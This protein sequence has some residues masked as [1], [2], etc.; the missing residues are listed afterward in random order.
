[1]NDLGC[2]HRHQRRRPR[3]SDRERPVWWT[4]NIMELSPDA[5]K[6]LTTAGSV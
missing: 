5:V 6:R 1:L 2:P 4:Y 3:A